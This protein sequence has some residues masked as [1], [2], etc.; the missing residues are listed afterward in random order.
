MFENYQFK[1]N[2][3]S[4]ISGTTANRI[5][6]LEFLGTVNEEERR[7]IRS[8]FPHSLRSKVKIHG[9]FDHD[10]REWDPENEIF[11]EPPGEHEALDSSLD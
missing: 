11:D 10:L 8:A 6:S 1:K 3:D 4:W 5:E 9:R 2:L 7:S